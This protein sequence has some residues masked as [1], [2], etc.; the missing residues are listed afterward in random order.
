MKKLLSLLLSLSFL[1]CLSACSLQSSQK[2]Y[3]NSFIDLFD[4]VS[5]VTAYDSSEHSFKDRK[6]VV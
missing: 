3:T 2:R 6:S 4:T 5:S 1:F